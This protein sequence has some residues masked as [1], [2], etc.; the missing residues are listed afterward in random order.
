MPNQN[1][2]ETF[3]ER[4]AVKGSSDRSFG[5]VF[6]VVFSVVGLV[7]LFSGSGPRWWSIGLAAI[8]L[9]TALG[10]PKILAP[11]NRLWT[12]FGLLLHRIVNPIIM[13]LL[14]FLV[15]TPIAMIMRLVG[16]RPLHLEQDP[17]VTT[18][19]ISRDPP[20]PPPETMKQQF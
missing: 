2:H 11:L 15:V 9:V 13:G 7:P 10:Y 4:D 17:D 14:F 12:R 3:R 6:A 16:K 8:F 19:W 18:Y 5:I 1:S 20:G